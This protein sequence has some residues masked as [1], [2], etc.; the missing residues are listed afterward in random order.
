[1]LKQRERLAALGSAVA[2]VSHDLRNILTSAQLF[3]DRIDTSTDPTV[4]RMA[5]KLMNSISRAVNL[6]ERTLAF[7]KAEEPSPALAVVPL[8]M[9]AQDVIDGERLAVEDGTVQ[10]LQDVPA[11]TT[12]RA[13]PE[14][15][16]RVLSNLVRNARQAIAASGKPG[17]IRVAAGEGNGAWWIE[18]TDTGPGLPKRTQEHLFQPFQAGTTKGGAGLGLAIAAE[19]VKGHGG[20]LTLGQTGPDGTTFHVHLPKSV[21]DGSQDRAAE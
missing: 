15:M 8:A 18:V 7:G 1:M 11:G 13:D 12:V 16:Y 19:L 4:A 9:I 3:A 2:K 20:Q 5:P 6:C 10:F 17:E 14:Q 21:I